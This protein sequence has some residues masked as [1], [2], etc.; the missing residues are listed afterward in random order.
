[1]E[2]PPGWYRYTEGQYGKVTWVPVT[3]DQAAAE[4]AAGT[5]HDLVRKHGP[6]AEMAPLW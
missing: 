5:G 1:M 4:V 2:L 6:A 3:D